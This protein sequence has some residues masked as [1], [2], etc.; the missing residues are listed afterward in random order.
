M[1][2]LPGKNGYRFAIQDSQKKHIAN[3]VLRLLLLAS[4]DED[5]ALQKG[6]SAKKT[7]TAARK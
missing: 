3:F 6:T 1:R 2:S 7:K 4:G 5:A